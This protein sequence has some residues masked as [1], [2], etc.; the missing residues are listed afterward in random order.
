MKYIVLVIT[1]LTL[2]QRSYCQLIDSPR[3]HT[4]VFVLDAAPPSTISLLRDSTNI[5]DRVKDRLEINVKRL[6]ALKV[7]HI[8]PIRY[9]Y[10]INN[11]FVSQFFDANDL[12]LGGIIK[13]TTTIPINGIDVL[14][15]FN[16]TSRIDST[17]E[18]PHI[19]SKLKT[20]SDSFSLITTALNQIQLT[21]AIDTLEIE[22]GHVFSKKSSQKDEVT[23]LNR[24]IDSLIL[25]RNKMTLN[26]EHGLDEYGSVLENLTINNNGQTILQDIGSLNQNIQKNNLTYITNSIRQQV[27]STKRHLNLIDSL[28]TLLPI[29]KGQ[30]KKYS[31]T[32]T[33]NI[34]S[35]RSTKD[36]ASLYQELSSRIALIRKFA[37]NKA[38][39]YDNNKLTS[40]DDDQTSFELY[41]IADFAATEKVKVMEDFVLFVSLQIGKLLQ[42]NIVTCSRFQNY[43]KTADC[44]DSR[45]QDSISRTLMQDSV[46]YT[47]IQDECADLNVM[48]KY[49]QL[50]NKAFNKTV[51][52]INNNY[53]NLLK[54]MQTLDYVSNNNTRT[55]TMPS[56]NDLKNID[57]VRYTI[58]KHDKLTGRI[59]SNSYD[60][61]IRGGIKVDFSVAILLSN[62]V[63]EMYNKLP[64]FANSQ[65]NTTTG[66]YTA[67]QRT[68]S[69]LVKK[70][71]NGNRNFAFG[72][73]VNLMY[74]TGA[75]WLTPGICFGVVYGTAAN[76]KLQFVSGISLQLGKT[77]RLLMHLGTVCGEK[78]IL[79]FSQINYT[80][81]AGLAANTYKVYGDFGTAVIPYTYKFY[82][83]PF[84]GVSYN[85]SKKSPLTAIGSSATNYTN[86]Q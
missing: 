9:N 2:S 7:I 60:F 56:Y 48:I 22:H 12:I 45:L 11:Q 49:L 26:F 39:F 55:F 68:D 13:D 67:T 73:M 28:S 66:S 3:L 80:H 10:N 75:S 69:F 20:Y 64:M 16:D 53:K 1:L 84:L 42:D 34:T 37:S 57:L 32:F 46:L 6:S 41:H 14:Y 25:L 83:K 36:T 29:I 77:E 44:I 58:D 15:F 61:W 81:D 5:K 76:S 8:N 35:T 71:D 54:F 17:N 31:Y 4:D 47:Y 40:S 27:D 52:D 23:K 65:L 18:L 74:R 70:A 33:S 51:Q 72:G 43:I 63:D 79:D 62:L 30:L 19:K 85:L 59:E 21:A 86:A 38:F 50:N 24:K 78:Q 82:F